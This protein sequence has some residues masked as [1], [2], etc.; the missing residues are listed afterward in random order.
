MT[1][2]KR[3]ISCS[4]EHMSACPWPNNSAHTSTFTEVSV[5]SLL[6]LALPHPGHF[7]EIQESG[8]KENWTLRQR[9]TLFFPPQGDKMAHLLKY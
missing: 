8:F 4:L 3:I 6:E 9:K 5:S 2:T 1:K 7:T